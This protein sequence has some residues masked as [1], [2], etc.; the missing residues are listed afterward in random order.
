MAMENC[1]EFMRCGREVGGS[2]VGELGVCPAAVGKQYDGLNRGVNAGRICWAVAG[3]LCEGKP[4]GKF[5]TKIRTCIKC[6]FY[7]KVVRE[8]GPAITIYPKS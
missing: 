7:G 8:E 4:A 6:E 1:W 3:T 5:A 2:R